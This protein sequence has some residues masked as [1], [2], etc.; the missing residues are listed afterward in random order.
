MARKKFDVA[1]IQ[2]YLVRY[3]DTL[4]CDN[5]WCDEVL[6]VDEERAREIAPSIAISPVQY[7]HWNGGFDFFELRAANE[8]IKEALLLAAAIKGALA[9]VFAAVVKLWLGVD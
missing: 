8:K 6:C 2:P 4:P 5:A 1:D 3:Y 9:K 7:L